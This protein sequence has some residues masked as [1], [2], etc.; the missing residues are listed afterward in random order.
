MFVFL[1]SL[2]YHKYKSKTVRKNKNKKTDGKE[3]FIDCS[4]V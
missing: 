2:L 4:I 1:L 3:F